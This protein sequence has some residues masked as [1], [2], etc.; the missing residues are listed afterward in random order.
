GRNPK[1]IYNFIQS[2]ITYITKE[3]Y[4]EVFAEYLAIKRINFNTIAFFLSRYTLLRKR[5]K[6]AK[7]KINNNFEL[8]FLY[9]AIKAA[10]PINAIY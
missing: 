6:D 8:N 10:Y 2:Y 9:N 7:F 3:A 1:V 5:I 4:S